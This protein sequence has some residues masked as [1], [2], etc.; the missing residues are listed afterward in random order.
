MSDDSVSVEEAAERL[1]VS[2]ERVR[3][4]LAEG[5]LRGVDGRVRKESLGEEIGRQLLQS[6]KG[7]ERAV[8]SIEQN[9]LLSSVVVPPAMA[10]IAVF[11]MAYVLMLQDDWADL[12]VTP[13]VFLLLF[14]VALGLLA[15]WVRSQPAISAVGGM[16]SVLYGRRQAKHGRIA[17]KWLSFAMVPL[18]PLRSYVVLHELELS[19]HE[20]H[21]QL[22]P[23]PSLCWPQVLPLVL[24]VWL[25]I[26]GVVAWFVWG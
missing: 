25:G 18:V 3:E 21:Y 16:G 14:A 9:S 10:I 17:T 26:A 6:I 23:L 19:A 24:A 2:V 22:R 4:L 13:P 7:L 1:D 15:L 20:K 12:P 11:T 8:S 5:R